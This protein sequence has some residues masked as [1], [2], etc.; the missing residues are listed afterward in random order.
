MP[1]CMVVLIAG[2][3]AMVDLIISCVLKL[4]ECMGVVT[5][6]DVEYV[7]DGLLLCRVID[8]E[9]CWPCLFAWVGLAALVAGYWYA[10]FV[11][12]GAV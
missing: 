8:V 12:G 6:R 5:I 1:A 4:L 11:L 10:W 3:A 9:F 7:D 2:G